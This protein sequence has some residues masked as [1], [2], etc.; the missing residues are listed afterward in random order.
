MGRLRYEWW[1]G[2]VGEVW[3][4]RTPKHPVALGLAEARR[5]APGLDRTKLI[6]MVDGFEEH[7]LAGPTHQSLSA[8]S[9]FSNR[10]MLP[11]LHLLHSL[12]SPS[13]HPS[14]QHLHLA[15]SLSLRPPIS[16]ISSPTLL[17]DL[18]WEELTKAQDLL[19]KGPKLKE[20]WVVWAS[21][22]PAVEYWKRVKLEKKDVKERNWAWEVGKAWS[23]ER[24]GVRGGVLGIKLVP[25]QKQ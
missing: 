17:Y 2:A 6:E 3:E 12:F 18:A 10:T 13:P 5:I 21:A 9:R 4:G 15:I 8:F 23:R 19:Q 1:R 25:S 11:L 22:V 20:E 24:W 14:L 16:T 7:F